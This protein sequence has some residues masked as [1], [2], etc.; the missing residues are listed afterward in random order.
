MGNHVTRAGG[1]QPNLS[2][3]S[4]ADHSRSPRQPSLL[5]TAP[6]STTHTCITAS[7]EL[8]LGKSAAQ[9]A[10]T[11][12][13]VGWG[14]FISSIRSPPDLSPDIVR[15]WHPAGRLLDHIRRRGV[16]VP[17]TTSP[18]TMQQRDHAIH[19]G[20]HKS[21]RDHIPFVCDEMRDYIAQGYW[22]VLPYDA[23]RHIPN[24]RISPLGV[25]PQRDRRPRLIVDYS[26]S[27]INDETARLS[28][29]EAMQFGHAFSRLLTNLVHCNPRLGPARLAKIDIADGFYRIPL[30]AAD[31]PKLGVALPATQGP[32][33]VAFP[34]SLPMGWVESPPYFTAATETACDLA[35]HAIRAGLRP[36]PGVHR[37][38]ALASTPPVDAPAAMIPQGWAAAST[39]FQPS[40]C[41][42]QPPL[43]YVDVYVDDFLLAAQTK[44]QQT[45]VL[46]HTLSA[47][48]TIFRPLQPADPP[49]R[50]EPTSTKKLHQ[51]DAHWSHRKRML[52]WDIDTIAETVELPEHRQQRLYELLDQ[53]RPP[54][55]RMSRS[56]WHQLLGE[57][58]SMSVGL[59]GSRGLFSVL[60]D[61]LR[62]GDRHRVRLTQRIFDSIADFRLLA[63]SLGN[64][65]TRFRE[66]VP[67][68]PSDVGACDA[69]RRGMGGIWLD[70]LDAT[71]PP[72][73]WR[74]PFPAHIQSQLVTSA[75]PTGTLSISDL[76]LAATLTHRMV[77][78]SDRHVAERTIWLNGD[79]RAAQ[80]W[81]TKGSA[82]A[83]TARAYLLR[84][85]ALHQRAHRYVARHHYIPGPANAMADDA[86][87][88]WH[89]SDS[90][91]LTHFNL[92][93]PQNASWCMSPPPPM[94]LSAVIGALSRRR[95]VPASL[96]TVTPPRT[97]HGSS[98][99]PF[100]S[101]WPS[102]PSSPPFRTGSLFS[103]SSRTNTAPDPSPPAVTLSALAQW[104]TPY[105]RWA[106]RLP[107]WGPQTLA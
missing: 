20:S 67:V 16:W 6:T 71:A 70:A 88:L 82:T 83:T 96:L 34:L 84:L 65:P 59:P 26:F 4:T 57:L 77:L 35:N 53:V 45:A 27:G 14:N 11:L 30:R 39:A 19:R 1:N 25:V 9:A 103:C 66:L 47:I 44:R 37:L 48:D 36:P 32:L 38:E 40:L 33:L 105:E 55:R 3:L 43:A 13:T 107:A 92:H 2:P 68:A 97:P 100:V 73:L 24:L 62:H 79:N 91:L 64:R 80:C 29:S 93:Y 10:A 76:E 42:A 86:S 90:A 8:N 18:W 81:A 102:T 50:K 52:G 89:L 49:S 46:R 98:G 69:C 104:K 95:R 22:T 106:R 21:A 75:H 94:L 58:R 15:T 5:G 51:G 17:L 61:A 7:A 23:V 74:A 63:D 87:R 56:N 12:A 101:A 54:R 99:R 78:S 31:V 60:Q 85:G 72:L 28:P 41:T